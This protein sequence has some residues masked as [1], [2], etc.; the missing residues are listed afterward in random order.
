[1]YLSIYLLSMNLP[2]SLSHT[3][4]HTAGY[5]ECTA[6]EL[7]TGH[8]PLCLIRDHIYG[9]C[10]C[11]LDSFK[12]TATG[13]QLQLPQDFCA[14]EWKEEVISSTLFTSHT[15]TH[16]LYT[17]YSHTRTHAHTHAEARSFIIWATRRDIYFYPLPSDLTNKEMTSEPAILP[18]GNHGDVVGVTYDPMTESI[19]WLE[20]GTRLLHR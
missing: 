9:T 2:L 11:S 10:H 3:H 12:S 18:R 6:E 5:H 20:D 15:H 13:S 7:C 4:T 14:S 1:M 17:Y 16:T 19:V 8:F